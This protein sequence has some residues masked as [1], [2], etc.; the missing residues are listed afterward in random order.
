MAK[1]GLQGYLGVAGSDLAYPAIGVT[2]SGRGVLAMTSTGANTF[3]SAA[4]APIDA[5]V[6]TG[7]VSMAAAGQAT[8]DGFTSYG[9]Q[10]GP[11]PRTRW[12]DYGAAAVDDKSV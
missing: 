10:V 7:P 3:P 6:G 9:A 12:G 1:M 11:P 5:R 8:N 4:Y 2:A